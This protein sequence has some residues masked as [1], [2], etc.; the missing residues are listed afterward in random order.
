MMHHIRICL[1]K[2]ELTKMYRRRAYSPPA[3]NF[4]LEINR[5]SAQKKLTSLLPSYRAEFPRNS[6]RDTGL[7]QLISMASIYKSEPTQRQLDLQLADL[8]GAMII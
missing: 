5:K 1:H 2:I 7:S 8:S 6:A 4:M 3:V